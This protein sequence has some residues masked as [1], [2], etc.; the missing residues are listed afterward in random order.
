MLQV[1]LVLLL[2]TVRGMSGA[3]VLSGESPERSSHQSGAPASPASSAPASPA[4]ASAPASLMSE[5]PAC[6]TPSFIVIYDR[7][8]EVIFHFA[9]SENVFFLSLNLEIT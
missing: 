6:L 8:C 4:P 3:R 1:L 2:L 7:D 5:R 9:G